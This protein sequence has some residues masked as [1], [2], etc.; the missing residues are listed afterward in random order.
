MPLKM[1]FDGKEYSLHAHSNSRSHAEA[2]AQGLRKRGFK[3][4]VKEFPEGRYRFK[5]GV[6][7]RKS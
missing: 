2:I 5:F 6:Y 7:K 1:T 4:K 3:A